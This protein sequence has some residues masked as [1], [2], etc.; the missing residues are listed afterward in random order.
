MRIE[1]GIGF[2]LTSASRLGYSV[3]VSELRVTTLTYISE[4]LLER[5]RVVPLVPKLAFGV[6]ARA[7][8]CVILLHNHTVVFSCSDRNDACVHEQWRNVIGVRVSVRVSAIA[9]APA[10]T[11]DGGTALIMTRFKVRFKVRV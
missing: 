1:F 2:V 9:T 10:C 11:P 7:H 6:S 3:R 4:H 5:R 8:H